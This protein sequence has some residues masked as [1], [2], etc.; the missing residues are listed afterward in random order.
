MHVANTTGNTIPSFA[1]DKLGNRIEDLPLY[2]FTDDGTVEIGLSWTPES[3]VPNEPTS[4]IMD[5]FEYPENSRL[6]LWPYNFVI[7]QNGTEIYRTD[8]ITQVGSSVQT[9]TFSS[10]GKTIIRIESGENKS[11]FVQFG[12]VVYQNPYDNA[13]SIQNVSDD[14][15]RLVSPLTLVYAVYAIIIILPLSL[16]VILILYKKKKI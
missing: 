14:S 1:V 2:N 3:V 10:P 8:E 6:H 16:V 4:F 15:F 12:T 13:E 5:F 9:Y 11:S 7:I